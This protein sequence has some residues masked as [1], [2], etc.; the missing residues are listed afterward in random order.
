LPYGQQRPGEGEGKGEYRMLEFNHFERE[1]NTFR[2]HSGGKPLFYLGAIV[3]IW[4]W[5][6]CWN[7]SPCLIEG[8]SG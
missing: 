5:T 1:A 7:R 3:L 6:K 4:A 8:V 2:E